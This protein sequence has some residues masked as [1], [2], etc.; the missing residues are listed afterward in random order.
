MLLNWIQDSPRSEVDLISSGQGSSDGLKLSKIIDTFCPLAICFPCEIYSC[1]LLV[2]SDVVTSTVHRMLLKELRE[3]LASERLLERSRINF[4]NTL[5]SVGWWG[6]YF[7][8]VFGGL[9][10]FLIVMSA[11]LR[12]KSFHPLSGQ[13]IAVFKLQSQI[14]EAAIISTY[15]VTDGLL[16][17]KPNVS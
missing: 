13:P 1:F 16:P 17:R 9:G 12:C 2:T 14:I 3:W 7:V 11:S 6:F 5:G 15:L 8:L 4:L 10:F